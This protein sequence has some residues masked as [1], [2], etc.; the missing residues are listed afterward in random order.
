MCPAQ[1]AK[2]N[3]KFFYLHKANFSVLAVHIWQFKCVGKLNFLSYWAPSAPFLGSPYSSSMQHL[4]SLNTE[5][6]KVLWPS[7][8][9][10]FIGLWSGSLLWK[11][12]LKIGALLPELV[13]KEG[14]WVVLSIT[15]VMLLLTRGRKRSGVCICK[16]QPGK[17]HQGPAYSGTGTKK[18]SWLTS[19]FCWLVGEHGKLLELQGWSCWETVVHTLVSLL[20]CERTCIRFLYEKKNLGF[21]CILIKSIQAGGGS[22]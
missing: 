4:F 15:W 17:H 14:T 6:R 11:G 1:L 2:W 8:A 12:K 16:G 20:S 21:F 7:A 13:G 10:N 3:I 19:L 18:K 22:S 5:H 9:T